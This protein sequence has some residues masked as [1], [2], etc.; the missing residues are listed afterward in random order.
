M[1]T[2]D[3]DERCCVVEARL[4]QKVPHERVE[5]LVEAVADDVW[6]ATLDS[7]HERGDSTRGTCLLHR[8]IWDVLKQHADVIQATP[9][10]SM[11]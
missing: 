1:A 2:T 9:A 8:L 3:A 6:I 4:P 10:T 5:T 11:V 7:K